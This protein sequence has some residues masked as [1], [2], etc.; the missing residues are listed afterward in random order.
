MGSPFHS[1]AIILNRD[2]VKVPHLQLAG[3][4]PRAFVTEYNVTQ[5]AAY[6][7]PA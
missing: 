5:M 3:T 1:T 2:I 6:R 4:C 7:R